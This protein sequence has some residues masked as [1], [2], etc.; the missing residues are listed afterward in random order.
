MGQDEHPPVRNERL[1]PGLPRAEADPPEPI[2]ELQ[3]Q[4]WKLPTLRIQETLA[5]VL[6]I[7]TALLSV[8]RGIATSNKG[9]N[10][11]GHGHT[12]EA[13]CDLLGCLLRPSNCEAQLTWMR[14]RESSWA[15]SVH[16]GFNSHRL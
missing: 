6:G 1:E 15:D 3:V 10:T 2:P 16:I 11:N 9:I 7:F 4:D 14:T 5:T 12:G 13:Q 8:T